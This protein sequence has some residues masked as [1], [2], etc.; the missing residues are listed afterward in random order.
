[1]GLFLTVLLIKLCRLQGSFQDPIFRKI[2]I[3]HKLMFLYVTRKP[4]VEMFHESNTFLIFLMPFNVSC[5]LLFLTFTIEENVRFVKNFDLRF[6]MHLYVL[7]V[8]EQNLSPFNL[9][10]CT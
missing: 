5:F 8:P 3:E 1:M 10:D 7:E 6:P 4:Q 2:I 9:F